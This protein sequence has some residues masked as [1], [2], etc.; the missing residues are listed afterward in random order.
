MRTSS[1]A[2]LLAV[3]VMAA[4]LPKNT[5]QLKSEESEMTISGTS[6]LHDWHCPVEKIAGTFANADGATGLAPVTSATVTVQIADIECGKKLMNN[7]LRDALKGKDH[8]AVTFKLTS[9]MPAGAKWKAKGN[10][11]IAGATHPMEFDVTP[12]FENGTYR[13]Q[14]EV[15]MSLDAMGLERPSALLG[16]VKTGDEIKVNFNVVAR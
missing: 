11:A 10:L 4:A 5:F 6:S 9:V 16:T 1:L 3:F 12:A 8:P 13:F 15:T 2:L 7:K 14:G